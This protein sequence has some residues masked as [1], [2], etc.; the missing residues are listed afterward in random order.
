M[1]R[2]L[3]REQAV[4]PSHMSG[5]PVWGLRCPSPAC[6]AGRV[7][8]MR[9][10]ARI[11]MGGRAATCNTASF[12]CSSVEVAGMEGMDRRPAML[13]RRWLDRFTSQLRQAFPTIDPQEASSLALA[14]GAH[15]LLLAPEAAAEVIADLLRQ[16]G[17]ALSACN[18][19]SR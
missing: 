7:P 2:D 17:D 16:S 11:G 10:P 9:R 13:H 15:T 18:A 14:C 12:P 1:H 6:L 8:S 4:K 5:D 19:G 3:L